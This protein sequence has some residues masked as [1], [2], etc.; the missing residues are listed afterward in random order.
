[1]SNQSYAK[2]IKVAAVVAP[3]LFTGVLTATQDADF[4][5]W[6]DEQKE[7][8]L[9]SAEVIAMK[10]LKVGV[11]NSERATLSRGGV[12]HGG[13]FQAIDEYK[14]THQSASG[15]EINFTDS[16]KY[17]VAAYRLDRMI[18]L[19]LVPVSVVRKI[20]GTTG[21]MTWWID[22]VKMMELD[23]HK[24]GIT[25]P[26][27]EAWNDQMYNVRVLN[28]L[29]YNVDPNL[30]NVLITDDWLPRPI[31]FT[32][33]FR[34]MK[35]L[36]APKNLIRVDRRVYEGLKGLTVEALQAELGEYLPKNAIRAILSRRDRMVALFDARI[37][38][39][40]EA[41]VVCDRPGH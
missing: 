10:G 4:K 38:E 12:V 13:H 14:P 19:N 6:T 33:A 17:N 24:K 28:E 2:R 3:L 7:D 36:R 34:R 41:E 35:T 11:T 39:H 21:A 32:R 23:R 31:D 5:Q 25:P 37:A 30:G 16:Y 18:N 1:M 9:Q 26:N 29:I 15:T 8:F 40:G 20:K 22:D 27:L